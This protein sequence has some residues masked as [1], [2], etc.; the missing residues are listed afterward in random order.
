MYKFKEA[1]AQ[2]VTEMRAMIEKSQAEKRNLSGDE[3]AKFDALK[4]KVTELEGQEARAAFMAD[5]ERRMIGTPA[6]K[7]QADLESN[8]SLLEVIRSQVEGRSLTGAAF[9]YSQEEARRTGKPAQGIYVPMSAFEKRNTTTSAAGIVPE[10]F[11][12]DQFIG[13]L[14]N[15]LLMRS[16]GIRVLSGLRGDISIPKYKTGMTAGWVNEN[17]ALSE[18]G[19]TFETIGLKPRHVGAL[20]EMSRQLLQQSDP[21]IEQL[22]RDDLSFVMA[23]ALDRAMLTG[24]GIKAPLGLLNTVG[25]QTASLADLTFADVL[26]M[27][28]KLDDLNI[29]NAQFLTNPKTAAK[30]RTT[31]KSASSGAEYLMAGG[32]LADLAV[33]VTNQVPLKTGTPNTGRIICGD[34]SQVL[35]GLWGSV[36]ILSNPYSET[37]YA[38]G[39]VMIRALMTAD[40]SVRHPGAFVV[41]DDVTL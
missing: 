20:G 15:S 9:E 24:D 27:V 12:P 33:S 26:A 34:F 25:I 41:A 35:L 3:I 38:R 11:R 37:A 36:D 30:F 39:G 10:N 19:M 2:A 5:A 21:S 23:E 8:V 18:S 40:M 4:T 14:R 6:D 32:K 28:G 17:E 29:T 31:L 13:P 16:L 22:V 7:S 1:K